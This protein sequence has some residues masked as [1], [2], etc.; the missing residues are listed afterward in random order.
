MAA[1]SPALLA[2][3]VSIATVRIEKSTMGWIW[4]ARRLP[5]GVRLVSIKQ[6]N[7]ASDEDTS[8]SQC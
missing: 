8:T 5:A 1:L 2:K 6:Q 3:Q 7:P 4:L